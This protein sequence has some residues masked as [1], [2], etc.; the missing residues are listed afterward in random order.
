[1]YFNDILI[2]LVWIDAILVCKPL[3]G[4]DFAMKGEVSNLIN[5]EI[6]SAASANNG[7]QREMGLSLVF[8]A[9]RGGQKGKHT[10]LS[11][12]VTTDSGEQGEVCFHSPLT[13]SEAW[14][15]S[16]PQPFCGWLHPGSGI[17]QLCGP[18]QLVKI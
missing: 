1:M 17:P 8:Q 2:F 5:T 13:S 6:T 4:D 16:I 7:E 18:P 9:P 3:W 10:P 14:F 15:V 11:F 12:P